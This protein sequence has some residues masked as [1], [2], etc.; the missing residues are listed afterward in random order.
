VSYDVKCYALAEAFL[1]DY[2]LPEPGD[3][4]TIAGQ[5]AQRIQTGIEDDLSDLE[6]SGKIVPKDKAP[7]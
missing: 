3:W 2:D 6:D 1:E 7:Q 5:L 4:R